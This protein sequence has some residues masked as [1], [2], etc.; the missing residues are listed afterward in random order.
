MVYNVIKNTKKEVRT[1]LLTV[2]KTTMKEWSFTVNLKHYGELPICKPESGSLI[3][4]KLLRLNA[5]KNQRNRFHGQK[6]DF[7]HILLV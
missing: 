1:I 2:L 5:S 3:R 6:I 7:A 4:L